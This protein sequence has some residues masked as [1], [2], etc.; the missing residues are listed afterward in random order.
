MFN[1]VGDRQHLNLSHFL[2][3]N[4]LIKLVGLKLNILKYEISAVI[5]DKTSTLSNNRTILLSV[6]A[7]YRLETDLSAAT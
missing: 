4:E 7:S 2:S 3:H 5:S 6:T 1:G